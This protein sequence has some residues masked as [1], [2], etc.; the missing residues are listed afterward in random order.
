MEQTYTSD[1][2]THNDLVFS[3][4]T[5]EMRKAWHVHLLTDLPDAHGQGRIIGHYCH[6]ALYG[7]DELMRRKKADFAAL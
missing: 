1:V 2:Q 7:V 4:Y 5:D 6:L 3:V